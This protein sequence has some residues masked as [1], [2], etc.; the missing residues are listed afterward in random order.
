MASGRPGADRG[1]TTFAGGSQKSVVRWSIYSFKSDYLDVLS[2]NYGAGINLLDFI[3]GQSDLRDFD[4]KAVQHRENL[5][6]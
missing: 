5:V 3:T 2:T 4:G 6:G 1:L